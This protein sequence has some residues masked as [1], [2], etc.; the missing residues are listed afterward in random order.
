[1]KIHKNSFVN[2]FLQRDISIRFIYKS[3]NSTIKDKKN[4]NKETKTI[5]II[6]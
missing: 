2:L 6:S 4:K 1:M 3:P 5:E